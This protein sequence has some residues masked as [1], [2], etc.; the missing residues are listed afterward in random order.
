MSLIITN[1]GIAASIKAGELGVS[2]KITHIGIGLDGYIPAEDQT[3]LKNEITPRKAITRGAVPAPGQLHF[4]TVFDDSRE[5]KVKE[6]GYYLEDGTLF[7][8]DSRNGEIMSL[9]LA[10]SIITEVFELN[11]AGP[12]RPL[13][14]L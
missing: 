9:K 13:P 12:S 6:I 5:Y 10:D 3:D 2:Y 14:R 8:V 1:A 7:A 4:E 11:L